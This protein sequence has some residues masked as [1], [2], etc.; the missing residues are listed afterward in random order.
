MQTPSKYKNEKALFG[1][2]GTAENFVLL[3]EQAHMTGGHAG[4]IATIQ[5]A[6]QRVI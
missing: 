1:N 3:K 2:K 6:Q 5:P 4:W